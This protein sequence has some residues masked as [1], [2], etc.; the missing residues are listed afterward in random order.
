M[1]AHQAVISKSSDVK[2]DYD[3]RVEA[4]NVLVRGPTF[5]FTILLVAIRLI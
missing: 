2:P 3:S 5:D 4:I 1:E